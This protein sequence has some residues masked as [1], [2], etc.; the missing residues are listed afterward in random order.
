MAKNPMKKHLTSSAIKEM[1]IIST[2]RHYFLPTSQDRDTSGP[3]LPRGGE[4]TA[5][6]TLLR[7]HHLALPIVCAPYGATPGYTPK[8]NSHTHTLGLRQECSQPH[9]EK[10]HRQKNNANAYQH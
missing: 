5:L 7:D 8:R 6:G 1:K 2:M 3:T 10:K 4:G 9:P